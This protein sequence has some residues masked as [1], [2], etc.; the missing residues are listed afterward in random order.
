M[1]TMA[2]RLRQ[3]RQ[4][5]GYDSAQAAAEAFGWNP[6]AFRHHEN[7]TRRFGPD[8]AKKY[9]RAFK[10]RPGWLL[11]LEHVDKSPVTGASSEDRLVVN[12]SVEAGA[13]RAS[14]HWNDER[15]F[16]IEGMP[17]P[18]TN[19]ERFGLI[20]VG[21]SMDEFYEPGSV[22]DCVSIFKG[23]VP[24]Q[25]GDHVIVERVRPDGL[26]ELTVKEYREQGDRYL[27]V[28]R[29]T[30]PGYHSLDYPGPDV[31]QAANDETVQVI[32]FVITAYPPRTI[33]LMRRM[34]LIKP[35][36]RR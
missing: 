7:G 5:A 14:E 25:S 24:P 36:L 19:A 3:A 2:E 29:S 13:W 27:L 11:G 20:T 1:A 17:S 15:A 16:V 4:E 30:K 31:E 21:N 6:A 35:L 10:V 22:L 9:G 26:R 28:P 34:G 32:G 23:G 8:A 18:V 33:D 12:G